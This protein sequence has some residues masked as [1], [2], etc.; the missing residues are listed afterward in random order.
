MIA[1][2]DIVYAVYDQGD[3]SGPAIVL[4]TSRHKRTLS[5][6]EGRSALAPQL[7][8]GATITWE[9]D[10]WHRVLV[11]DEEAGDAGPGGW[12]TNGT[13]RDWVR[14]LIAFTEYPS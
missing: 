14:V 7:D 6:E 4:A 2:G 11:A 5:E 1:P 8:D 12:H 13:G 9:T 10:T 3:R